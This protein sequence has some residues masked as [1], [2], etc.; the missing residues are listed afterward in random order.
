[1]Q[2]GKYVDTNHSSRGSQV[3]IQ[4]GGKKRI[5]CSSIQGRDRKYARSNLPLYARTRAKFRASHLVN[6]KLDQGKLKSIGGGTPHRLIPNLA[7][8]P[9]LFYALL[10]RAIQSSSSRFR[11]YKT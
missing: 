3:K 2:I 6:L 5:V 8:Q 11:D 7:T 1:L 10:T 4:L 9:D